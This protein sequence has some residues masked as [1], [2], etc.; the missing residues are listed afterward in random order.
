MKMGADQ[1]RVFV[2]HYVNAQ[3]AISQRLVDARGAVGFQIVF[4]RRADNQLM[5]LAPHLPAPELA[6]CRALLTEFERLAN[7]ARMAGPYDPLALAQAKGAAMSLGQMQ[8]LQLL[9]EYTTAALI[10][11]AGVNAYLAQEAP[12]RIAPNHALDIYRQALGFHDLAAIRR[13]LDG[14]A[15]HIAALPMTPHQRECL[16]DALYQMARRLNL[17]DRAFGFLRMVWDMRPSVQ[18]AVLLMDEAA[19]VQDSDMVLMAGQYLDHLGA[20]KPRHLAQMVVAYRRQGKIDLAHAVLDQLSGFD[21]DEALVLTQKLLVYLE[22]P[23][24]E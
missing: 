6:K 13:L 12:A 5:F 11:H 19:L 24:A 14:D 10:Y 7:L 18:R 20:L 3:P 15:P 2:A 22:N 16:L 17:R 4:L 1:A 8:Q 23:A 9:G 21:T